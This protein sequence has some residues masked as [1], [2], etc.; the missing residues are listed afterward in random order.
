MADMNQIHEFAVRWCE[1]FK[2][3]ETDY[4][5]L[6]DHYMADDC[7]ALGFIMDC[8]H[9]FS[10]KYGSAAGNSNELAK[11]IDEVDDIPLLGSAIY[12]QWRYFNHW[13]DSGEEI[14]EPRN[15]E[16]FILALNRLAL[17]TGDKSVSSQ[18]EPQKIRDGNKSDRVDRITVDYRRVT[19]I[20]PKDIPEGATWEYVTW[21]YTEKLVIDRESEILEHTQNIG[22]GCVVSR[23]YYVQGGI[24][25]LLDYIDADNLFGDIEGNPDDVIENP[26]ETQDYVIAVDFKKGP[27][28]MIQGTYDKKALPEFWG[29]FADDVRHFM[30]FYGFGEIL[31]PDI[32]G[33]AKRCKR[34]YMYCSV[35]FEGG[36]K[37]YYYI[38]D[39]DTIE[40]GDYV[41]V[42]AGKD[43]HHAMVEVV[44]I[45]YFSEAEAP[46]PPEKTKHIIRKCTKEDFETAEDPNDEQRVFC[47][48]ANREIPVIDCIEICDVAN[49]CLH[50]DV[51]KTF[52]PPIE[53]NEERKN[54]CCS[55]EYNM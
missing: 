51:L 49:E 33:K 1:K 13:A 45:E 34:D 17:L 25:D 3:P 32:Y 40:V 5:E 16:W 29:E 8:G 15:R 31:D 6:V 43:N 21:D 46:L 11:I 54:Q 42:P 18:E 39:D 2:D 23:K 50:P 22:S 48:V 26:L 44:E 52:D 35:E 9:A 14:L 24:E 47:P 38:S 12:S 28:R 55:C 27:Q 36:Y 37:T 20:K 4:I 19:K 7:E 41:V 53:W 30:L 10:E